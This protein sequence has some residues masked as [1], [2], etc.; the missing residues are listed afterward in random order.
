[1]KKP[2]HGGKRPGA[3]RPEKEPTE[4]ITFRVDT[5]LK[6]DAKA[7]HGRGLNKKANAWLSEITYDKINNDA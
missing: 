7:K 4:N 2:K 5:A 1:M 6:L 3:G